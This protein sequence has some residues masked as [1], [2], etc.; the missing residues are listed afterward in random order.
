[1]AGN[2]DALLDPEQTELV[3]ELR[4]AVSTE[5]EVQRELR[6]RHADGGFRAAE[7]V[8]GNLLHDEAVHGIVLTAHDV[9]ERRVLEDQLTHQAFHDA[10]TGLPNRA[11]LLNRIEHALERARRSGD[12]VALLF[13]DLDDFKTINDSL[14]HA[15]GDELLVEIAL[16]LQESLRAADT[17]ARLGGD[18][19]ALLLEGT[20]GI[21][22]ATTAADR[23]LEAVARP[24][25]LGSTEVL[26][27]A[28]VGIV[29]GTPGQSAGELLRNADM[30]MYRAKNAGGNRFEIFEPEM[31]EAAI[32]RL[33]LKADLE[34]AFASNELDL[35]YQPLV[36]LVTGRTLSFEALLR[37]KHPLRGFV[38]PV[39]FI[40]LAEETGLINHIGH[41]VLERAC[42]QTRVWQMSVPGNVH[43]A[44]N[45]NLSARQI[46]QPRFR[47]EVA[48]VLVDTGLEA[49]QL[50]LEITE[51]TLLE[52]V[53]GVSARLAELRAMGIRIAIDD[54]GTGFSSLG[55]LQRFP[56]DELK[57]AR[58][59]VDEVVRDPRR[60]RLVEAIVA[61]AHSLEMTTV[62]EGIEEPAQ[63]QRLQELGCL[64]GQGYLFSRPVPASDVPALLAVENAA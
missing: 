39:E 8:F 30:A 63:R 42:R 64:V 25:K 45:V 1:M 16:R 59:F 48:Q 23:L 12:D 49:T 9:T 21:A 2:L 38:P 7:C 54:F 4:D 35:H 24:M 47:E 55:Y 62:A 52:D 41:W 51:G 29:F 46:L 44:I 50:V 28:S 40:P 58:E 10:L 31:H 32:T 43:L 53:E 14:G 19:F 3:A 61:L 22:G 34:R 37:W 15:A 60:A 11:L 5:P 17:A 13:L 36:D 56:A 26:G 27:R 20:H 18:E 6:L 57:V 33:E